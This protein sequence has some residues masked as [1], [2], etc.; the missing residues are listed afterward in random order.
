MMSLAS[1][2]FAVFFVKFSTLIDYQ[3]VTIDNTFSTV[4]FALVIV[5]VF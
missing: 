5:S 1:I 2:C 4:M 3:N